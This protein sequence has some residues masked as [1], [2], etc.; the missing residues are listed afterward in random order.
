MNIG[1]SLKEWQRAYA[2][3][4]KVSNVKPLKV[5]HSREPPPQVLRIWFKAAGT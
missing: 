2:F 5:L 3:Q 1:Y 4:K